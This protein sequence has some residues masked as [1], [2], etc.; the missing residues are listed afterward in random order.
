MSY[1]GL[2]PEGDLPL[3]EMVRL[4]PGTMA[5]AEP[6]A[7]GTKTF[8]FDEGRRA[9]VKMMSDASLTQFRN[10]LHWTLRD[11]ENAMEDRSM[12]GRVTKRDA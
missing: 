7:S 3:H 10:L 11:V 8:L 1:S 2:M 4:L 9:D 6:E 5:Y 12:L